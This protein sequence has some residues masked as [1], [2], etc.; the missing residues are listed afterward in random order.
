MLNL[1]HLRVFYHAARHLSFTQAAAE[2]FV[3]QP[4]VTAQI[5]S[6]ESACGLKLFRKRGRKVLLSHEGLTLYEL[7]RKVFDGEKEIENAVIEMRELRRGVL[8]IGSTKTYARYFMPYMISTFIQKYPNIKVLL[9]EGSSRDMVNSLLDFRNE[10]AIIAKTDENPNI[11]FIPFSQ[12]ELVVILPPAH[13]LAGR[14]L[15]SFEELAKEPVIMKEAGS[16]TRRVVNALFAR[17]GW[18]PRILME[19]SN[20]EF[21]KQLVQSG[22]GVSFLV[23]EAVLTELRDKRLATVPV[24]GCR[25]SLDVSIAYLKDQLASPPARAFLD[26]LTRL[27]P[28]DK[29]SRGIA[30]LMAKIR[31]S[32]GPSGPSGRPRSWQN[33]DR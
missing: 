24:K 12:E 18:T 17:N 19:T 4:A 32:P 26:L 5:K 8:R 10:V 6:L 13:R 20:A 33:L 27:S 28:S 16:G 23:K 15:I 30:D 14:K 2:L 25:M 21:I 31:I 29:P 22:E 11:H 9:D 7:A 1:H 3:T